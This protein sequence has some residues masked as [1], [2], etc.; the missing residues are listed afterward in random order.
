[1]DMGSHHSETIVRQAMG[2]QMPA[3]VAELI[4][5]ANGDIEQ[6]GKKLRIQRDEDGYYSLDILAVDAGGTI[7][8]SRTFGQNYIESELCD[9]VNDAW[10]N[11][12]RLARIKDCR[13]EKRV[14]V[15]VRG[16]SVRADD[17]SACRDDLERIVLDYVRANG[18]DC[19]AYH[20]EAFGL[21]DGDGLVVM[22]VLDFTDGDGLSVVESEYMR[23]DDCDEIND[24]NWESALKDG[25]VYFAYQ[26]LY[27]VADAVGNE[28]L[29]YYRFT[30]PGV[31]FDPIEADPEHGSASRLGLADL[32]SVIDGM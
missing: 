17:L 16:K 24:A 20:R 5:Y 27:I 11:V 12:R 29:M 10:A 8:E 18:E 26:C 14:H 21:Y 19:D 22:K 15:R 7:I 30:N 4:G 31:V 1:M 3:G 9:L 6:Y 28:C 13:K 25:F 2:G 23:Q 32:A